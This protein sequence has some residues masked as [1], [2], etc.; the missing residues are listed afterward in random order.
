MLAFVEAPVEAEALAPRVELGE[1]WSFGTVC[2]LYA[3]QKDVKGVSGEVT[4][5]SPSLSPP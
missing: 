3:P 1:D 5:P 4:S 2:G